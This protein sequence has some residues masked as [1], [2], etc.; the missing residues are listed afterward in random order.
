MHYDVEDVLIPEV[1]P[2]EVQLSQ[3]LCLLNDVFEIVT[4]CDINVYVLLQ[5][6]GFHLLGLG[7]TFKDLLVIVDVFELYL[8]KA[9]HLKPSASF[10][11][12]SQMLRSIPCYDCVLK[13]KVDNVCR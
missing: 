2:G 6:Q 4:Q 11:E 1:G 9:K 5:V 3:R 10:Q 13:P 7:D 12:V 8:D